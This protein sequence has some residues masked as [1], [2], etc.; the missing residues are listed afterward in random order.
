MCLKFNLCI[1]YSDSVDSDEIRGFDHFSVYL[2]HFRQ[3]AMKRCLCL[4]HQ[5]SLEDVFD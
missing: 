1:K 5:M 3:E 4:V 2:R